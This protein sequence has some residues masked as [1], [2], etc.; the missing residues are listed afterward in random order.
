MAQKISTVFF[1]LVLFF[2]SFASV[3]TSGSTPVVNAWVEDVG[4]TTATIVIEALLF[5]PTSAY[6]RV[7]KAG[8]G[9]LDW[10][11]KY[12]GSEIQGT[13][14]YFYAT[15][16]LSAFSYQAVVEA[17]NDTGIGGSVSIF[18]TTLSEPQPV[19]DKVIH[20]YQSSGTPPPSA[21]Q[22]GTWHVSDLQLNNESMY[23]STRVTKLV[24]TRTG[25][26]TDADVP[27]AY[28]AIDG[29]FFAGGD[30][31]NGV[32]DLYIYDEPV[33]KLPLNSPT[34]VQL[35]AEVAYYAADHVTFSIGVNSAPDIQCEDFD[36]TGTFPIMGSE[37]TIDNPPKP[38]VSIRLDDYEYGPYDSMSLYVHT[39]NPTE[40]N[41]SV[42]YK[43]WLILP[44][45]TPSKFIITTPQITVPVGYDKE[46]RLFTIK[47]LPPYLPEG[48]YYWTCVMYVGSDEYWTGV[49]WHFDNPA[50]GDATKARQY[51][52]SI[53]R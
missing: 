15:G 39:K 27:W 40:Y 34:I 5:T 25:T 19:D 4:E 3:A 51:K 43:L 44:D 11:E 8:G 30:F 9:E 10:S 23:T 52:P 37:F 32:A 47:D 12:T 49:S 53:N 31:Y 26:A 38:S 13:V 22:S 41:I 2:S 50:K 21:V 24:V 1:L 48:Y 42:R 33:N 17:Y 16:L 29:W 28:A 35:Y 14:N 46:V 18:F 20:V 7:Y 6:C 36:I 45:G